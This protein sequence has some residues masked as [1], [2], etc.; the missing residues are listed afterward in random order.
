MRL[1]EKFYSRLH[2]H[3]IMVD[4]SSEFEPDILTRE[5]ISRARVKIKL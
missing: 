4:Y 2:F 1:E 3:K 5:K